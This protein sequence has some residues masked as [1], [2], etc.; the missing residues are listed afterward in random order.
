[1]KRFQLCLF[2]LAMLLLPGTVQAGTLTCGPSDCYWVGKIKK[3]KLTMSKKITMYFDANITLPPAT[4]FPCA[5]STTAILGA[6]FLI[7]DEPVYAE[8]LYSTL[9]S[10]KLANSDVEVR[11][12]CTNG[13]LGFLEIDWITLL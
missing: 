10:A 6:K 13:T 12:K 1:M 4:N 3:I 9:L 11:F 5:T 2:A 7:S 8:Y